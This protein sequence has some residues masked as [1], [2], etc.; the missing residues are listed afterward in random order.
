[1]GFTRGE[2]TNVVLRKA[3]DDVCA[4]FRPVMHLVFLERFPSPLD[5]HRARRNY[6]KSVAVS[7]MVGYIVG[8]GDRHPNNI[9][10]DMR[11]GEL[12]HIDFG[13]TFDQ[14]R[15]LRMPE[16]V[17][18]RLSRDMVDGLG[19]L[20]TYGLF[21]RSCETSLS[22]L[23]EGSTLVNAVIEVFVHD[24]IYNWSCS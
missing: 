16:L 5:W 9:L 24:P 2:A 7:S 21:R 1:M 17:P 12:V 11:T 13:I 4:H 3:Y 6:A 20:G 15:A 23:R 10:F 19:C 8:I 22:V 14:G 18:C